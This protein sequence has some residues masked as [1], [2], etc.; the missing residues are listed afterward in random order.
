[1]LNAVAR[2][3]SKSKEIRVQMSAK[4]VY[5]SKRMGHHPEVS[6]RV[7][8]LIKVQKGRCSECGLHFRENDVLEVDHIIPTKLGGKDVYKNLQ[9]LHRHCHDK[10]TARD[11]SLNTTTK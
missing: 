3:M 6:N 9:L 4:V 5:W 7:A 8:I 10:K 11:G 2:A 1:M